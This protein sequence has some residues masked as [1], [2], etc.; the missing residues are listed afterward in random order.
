MDHSVK[1]IK[2]RS[3]EIGIFHKPDDLTRSKL[4]KPTPCRMGWPTSTVTTTTT[5]VN[6]A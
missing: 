1:K 3:T 4:C 2:S 6:L 5:P